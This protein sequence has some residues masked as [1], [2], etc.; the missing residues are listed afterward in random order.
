M[1]GSSEVDLF[2]Y[3]VKARIFNCINNPRFEV[4]WLIDHS[5]HAAFEDLMG[6]LAVVQEILGSL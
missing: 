3:S 5:S 4:E 2:S 6:K 1:D